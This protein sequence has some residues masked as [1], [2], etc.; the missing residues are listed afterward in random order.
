MEKTGLNVV[1]N[2]RK[3]SG[4][5][6]KLNPFRSPIPITIDPHNSFMS[7]SITP[8]GTGGFQVMGG[9]GNGKAS[10][11]NLRRLKKNQRR[12]RYLRSMRG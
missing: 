5:L 9:G 1:G 8:R 4:L 2:Y 10:M 3:F 11:G 7:S 6:K 12:K